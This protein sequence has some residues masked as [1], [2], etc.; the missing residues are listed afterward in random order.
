MVELLV[1]G[2]PI[3]EM[4]S[5][6]I[7]VDGEPKLWYEVINK[8]TDHVYIKAETT[9]LTHVSFTLKNNSDEYRTM[10]KMKPSLESPFTIEI[11]P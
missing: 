7:C 4:P 3:V 6:K 11:R 5:D 9:H 2:S 1:N 8:D 10:L